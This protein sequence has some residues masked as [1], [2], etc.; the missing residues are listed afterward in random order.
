MKHNYFIGYITSGNLC[1]F[2]NV[3]L[4]PQA[5]KL[6]LSLQTKPNWYHFQ[7]G[8]ERLHCNYVHCAGK[9]RRHNV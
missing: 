5:G 2:G 7:L 1:Y 9:C 4:V 3:W 8:D 6:Q